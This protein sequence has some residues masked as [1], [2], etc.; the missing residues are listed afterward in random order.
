[1]DSRTQTHTKHIITI[2]IILAVISVYV[3][4]SRTAPQHS[5]IHHGGAC[6]RYLL[7]LPCFLSDDTQLPGTGAVNVGVWF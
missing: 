5:D 3:S 4:V 6:W 1:M 2:I 7:S